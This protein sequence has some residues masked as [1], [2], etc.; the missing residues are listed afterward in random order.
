MST[1]IIVNVISK[2][3]LTITQQG[4]RTVGYAING[5]DPLLDPCVQAATVTGVPRYGDSYPLYPGTDL[6]CTQTKFD[7]YPKDS[8]TSVM[9]VA[10]FTSP[11]VN[12]SSGYAVRINGTTVQ[13]EENNY[14]DGSPY[15][16]NYVDQATKVEYAQSAKFISLHP[17][18]VLEIE[19]IESSVPADLLAYIGATNSDT[20]QGGQQ[21]C[22]LYRPPSVEL[23][24][25][26]RWRVAR[27][28]E[29]DPL[30][31]AVTASFTNK[32]GHVPTDASLKVNPAQGNGYLFGNGVMQKLPRTIPF[33]PLG[34]PTIFR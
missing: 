23:I 6:Y 24:G 7:P 29:Y 4:A 28:F 2:S 31:W 17:R 25:Q 15:V 32:E 9:C 26:N 1:G 34:M 18:L 30:T 33:A 22:W 20:W 16:V 3:S 19:R 11:T 10:T 21:Y 8:K 14:P 5:L 13:Y 27:C 12:L